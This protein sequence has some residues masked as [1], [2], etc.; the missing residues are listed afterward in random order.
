MMDVIV[1]MNEGSQLDLPSGPFIR[2]FHITMAL[3]QLHQSIKIG[4][5]PYALILDFSARKY[6]YM[7]TEPTE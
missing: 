6:S 3:F 2:P 4:V 1:S 5:D 7:S